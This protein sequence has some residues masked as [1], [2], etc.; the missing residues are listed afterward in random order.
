M[1]M[2]HGKG[3]YTNTLGAIYEGDWRFDMQHG[4]GTEKWINSQSLFTGEFENG[5]RNGHGIWVH[6]NKRYEGNWR[7]NMMEGQGTMEWGYVDPHTQSGLILPDELDVNSDQKG[8]YAGS[9]HSNK[10]NGFGVFK[11]ASG[12]LYVGEW[13]DDEKEGIGIQ[14]FK[15]GNEY[16]GEFVADKREG[17]GYY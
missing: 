17:Y 7:N 6:M 12:R 15:G 14:T 3:T 16:A 2:A 9:W 11:W 5:L 13:V 8:T 10:M 1:S 4:H